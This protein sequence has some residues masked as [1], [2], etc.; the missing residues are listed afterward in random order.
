MFFEAPSRVNPLVAALAGRLPLREVAVLRELSKRYEECQRGLL[1]DVAA[2]LEGI[3]ARGEY[4]VVVG[5]GAPQCVETTPSPPPESLKEIAAA[6]APRWGMTR[7][8][9]YQRLLS[10][11]QEPRE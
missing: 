2:R 1:P 5:P 3:E 7:R 11:E 6:L 4:V 10:L 8:E 9:A